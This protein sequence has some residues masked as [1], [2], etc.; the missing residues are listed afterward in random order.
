MLRGIVGLALLACL[1]TAGCADPFEEAGCT[2]DARSHPVDVARDVPFPFVDAAKLRVEACAT[3]EGQTP[4]CTESA[5]TKDGER[6]ALG[7]SLEAI[8]GSL[9]RADDGNT[10]L[11]LTIHVGEGQASTTT[12]L[13]VRVLDDA[14]REIAKAEGA[15]R[16]SDDECHP[17][18]NTSKI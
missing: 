11:L 3:R 18:P 10:K 8:T 5:A 14:D 4:T 6:L 13:L 9:T 15:V 17:A 12:Q 7:G 16:W 2:L 1:S